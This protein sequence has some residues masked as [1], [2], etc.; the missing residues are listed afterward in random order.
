MIFNRRFAVEN[1]GTRTFGGRQGCALINNIIN[2]FLIRINPLDPL[3]PCSIEIRTA[4]KL[5]DLSGHHALFVR[6]NRGHADR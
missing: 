6:L 5:R 3:N 1:N 2:G 4:Q